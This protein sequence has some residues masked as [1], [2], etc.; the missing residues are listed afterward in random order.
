VL[1]PRSFPGTHAKK[2]TDTPCRKHRRKETEEQ[3]DKEAGKKTQTEGKEE[4]N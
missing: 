4:E 3:E 2:L 1:Q